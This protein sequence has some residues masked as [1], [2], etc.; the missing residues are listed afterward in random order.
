MG[1]IKKSGTYKDPKW[2]EEEDWKIDAWD[3]YGNPIIQNG[4]TVKKV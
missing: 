2:L 3:K 4:K 1:D